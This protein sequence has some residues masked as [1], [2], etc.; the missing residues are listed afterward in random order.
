MPAAT[1][2]TADLA[3]RGRT[4]LERVALSRPV[5]LAV[6]D[7]LIHP[8]RTAVLD[9]GCGR[10]GDV[11][12]LR[13][14]GVRCAGWDP[15]HRPRGRVAPAAVVNLGFVVNVIEDPL[16]RRA[17][18]RRAWSLAREVLVVSA[19]L[20]SDAHDLEGVPFRDGVRTTSGTFQ[21]LYG[22][23]ELRGWIDATLGAES[24]AAAP[25]VFYVFRDR[26]LEQLWLLR[27]VRRVRREAPSSRALLERHEALLRPLLAFVEERGRLPRGGELA[28]RE[29][30]GIRAELGTLRN[31][32]AVVR[33][34]TGTEPWDRV[35]DVRSQELLVFLALA[36]F[37]RRPRPKELPAEIRHDVR[38]L[39]GS[40]AAACRQ[41]DRLLYEL[42]NQER[43]R[44]AATAS[45]VGKR[46]PTAL[47]LHA[48]ALAELPPILRLLDGV[49]RRPIGSVATATVVKLH[50]DQPAVSYLEYPD[51]DRDPHP[52]L[53][54]GFLVRVD[55]LRC[56]FRDYG[57]HANPPIL[58]RKELLL[59][60]DDP[61]RV[62]FAALTRQEERAGLYARPAAIGTR[63]AWQALLAERGVR[64]AGHRLVRR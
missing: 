10:G 29:E 32:F 8:G 56:E 45:A 27:R 22:Q 41:A 48:D 30:A 23:D 34:V 61:R 26:A 40:H 35:R 52:A 18:L 13:R 6:D 4:A 43:V 53:R 36:H 2:A 47:Y 42:A 9:Y 7:G 3:A 59:A 54:S 21:K 64:H 38:D 31:A 24:V 15:N 50:L 5:R 33:R 58:H 28:E 39:F 57:H 17:A 20:A 1:A 55:R 63:R 60:P 11:A 19:R 14:A 16:E 62:R 46:L 12:R 25:G 44:A 37:E 49:A 51:F